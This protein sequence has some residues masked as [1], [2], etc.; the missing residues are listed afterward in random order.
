MSITYDYYRNLLLNYLIAKRVL[1]IKLIIITR[2]TFGEL[3][4]AGVSGCHIKLIKNSQLNT[5][6]QSHI[7]TSEL[8]PAHSSLMLIIAYSTL[9]T[10]AT[11]V[12]LFAIACFREFYEWIVGWNLH[13]MK[14]HVIKSTRSAAATANDNVDARHSN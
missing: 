12:T 6:E 2:R 11:T 7:I 1:P 3:L 8:P 13:S 4:S 5:A 10:L 9:S 14:I